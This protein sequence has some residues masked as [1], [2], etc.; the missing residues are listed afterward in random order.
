M[1]DIPDHVLNHVSSHLAT[2]SE[3]RRQIGLARGLD[4]R[5]RGE[6]RYVDDVRRNLG[7]GLRRSARALREFTRMAKQN[8]VD[9]SRVMREM[10]EREEG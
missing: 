1:G 3:Y 2:Y 9:P 8:G 5:F 10:S 4:T 6:G 7:D